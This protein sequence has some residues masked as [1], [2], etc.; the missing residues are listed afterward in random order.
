MVADVVD[1]TGAGDA[2]IAG[3]LHGL[4]RGLTLADAVRVGTR[5][6]ARTVASPLSVDAGLSPGLA[7][8]FIEDV[9]RASR[10]SMP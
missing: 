9:L 7:D 3:T 10:I 5:I 6:A 1:V 2:M 4:G 8:G